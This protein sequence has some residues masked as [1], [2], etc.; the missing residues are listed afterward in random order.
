MSGNT[1]SPRCPVCKGFGSDRLGG[2]CKNHAE[3]DEEKSIY[4]SYLGDYPASEPF[5][6]STFG[7]IKDKFGLEK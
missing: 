4:D 1:T 7:I 2:Y 3:P 5:F 6:R